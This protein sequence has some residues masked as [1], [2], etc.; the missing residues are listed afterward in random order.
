MENKCVEKE[1]RGIKSQRPGKEEPSSSS[2]IIV[3]T[4]GPRKFLDPVIM[5][6]TKD[7]HT[8]CPRNTAIF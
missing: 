1:R 6:S 5:T 2:K 4:T 7:E 8:R 3:T